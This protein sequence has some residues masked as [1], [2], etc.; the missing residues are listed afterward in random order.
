MRLAVGSS[1]AET[2]ESSSH[3]ARLT[4]RAGV[5]WLLD[6]GFRSFRE[7]MATQNRI[8]SLRKQGRIQ[9]CLLLV[10]HPPTITLGRAGNRHHLLVSEPHLKKEGV[11]FIQTDRGGDITFHGPGQLVA[12]PIIDLK[13]RGRDVSIYLRQLEAC[14]SETLREF[15]IE[16]QRIPGSTGVWVGDQKIAA[17]GVRTSQWVTSHGL[18]LNVNTNLEYFNYI[19]PCGLKS[20]GVSSMRR[21]LGNPVPLPQVKECFCRHFGDVFNTELQAFEPGAVSIL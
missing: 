9:D 21:Q 5:C 17:I 13:P 11:E 10:E 15:G 7:S 8:V 1:A 3:E 14:I 4:G 16:S 6:L 18:A 19:V 2:I 20:K 12:Y